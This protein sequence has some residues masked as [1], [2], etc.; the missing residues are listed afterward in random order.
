MEQT[1]SVLG[2][3]VPTLESRH[4]LSH[5][6]NPG[7]RTAPTAGLGAWGRDDHAINPSYVFAGPG[8]ADE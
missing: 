4:V 2:Q 5:T 3:S 8:S 6:A 1:S 7:H